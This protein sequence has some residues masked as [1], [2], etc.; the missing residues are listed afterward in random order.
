VLNLEPQRNDLPF[1]GA[2]EYAVFSK[3]MGDITPTAILS[4][5]SMRYGDIS[6]AENRLV[7]ATADAED[8]NCSDLSAGHRVIRG[9][10]L[11]WFCSTMASASIP[12]QRGV[13]II[14][15]DI[16][17]KVDFAWAK[18]PFPILATNC[19]FQDAIILTRA[20]FLFLSLSKSTVKELV[21]NGAR[22]EDCLLL[23]DGLYFPRK[24][25]H[26]NLVN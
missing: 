17:G 11:S 26:G 9:K 19:T 10:V 21:A 2:F 5:I 16:D 14:G 23:N 4:E 15:A 24:N 18:I 22:F 12:P 3:Q 8:A 20:R 1:V 7:Q 25:G 13:S 6:P